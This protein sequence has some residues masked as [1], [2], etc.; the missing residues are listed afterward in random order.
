MTGG[1]D[2]VHDHVD[3]GRLGVVL[4]LGS[5]VEILS[6]HEIHRRGNCLQIVGAGDR[7]GIRVVGEIG[8]IHA[9]V[10]ELSRKESTIAVLGRKEQWVLGGVHV[11]CDRHEVFRGVLRRAEAHDVL[12]GKNRH[13]P[14]QDVPDLAV[15]HQ[16][17]GRLQLRRP[18][19]GRRLEFIPARLDGL[20][21]R[22]L[23]FEDAR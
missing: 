14:V 10:V 1:G 21:D 4:R 11:W 15:A 9:G 19:A 3:A 6:R 7:R 18:Q 16:E 8:G 23:G 22:N 17:Y 12:T 13:L 5:R 2:L 20:A